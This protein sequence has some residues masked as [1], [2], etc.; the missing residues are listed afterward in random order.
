MTSDEPLKLAQL[1]FDARRNRVRTRQQVSS[2]N[3]K[4]QNISPKRISGV[5]FMIAVGNRL[6]KIDGRFATFIEV[7][8]GFRSNKISVEQAVVRVELM[9]TGHPDLIERFAQFHR[10]ICRY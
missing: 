4:A 7:L 1:R 6:G 9:L 3:E 5:R 8:S 10:G 2:V